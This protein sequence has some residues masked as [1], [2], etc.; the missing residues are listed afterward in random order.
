MRRLTHAP[1]MRNTSF[2]TAAVATLRL[3]S[4][5]PL[6]G[7]TRP[8]QHM[9]SVCGTPFAVGLSPTSCM[10]WWALES[11]TLSFPVNFCGWFATSPKC[12]GPCAIRRNDKCAFV[13]STAQSGPL[14]QRGHG[15]TASSGTAK[16]A[17][18]GCLGPPDQATR[19]N[20]TQGGERGSLGWPSFSG[21]QWNGPRVPTPTVLN[22]D[23]AEDCTQI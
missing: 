12:F 15:H 1:T 18:G 19:H 7:G 17:A 14:Q 13:P 2:A 21:D 22:L 9:C 20:A 4:P 16:G 10:G 3:T 23:K 6:S 8:P 11:P 5:G